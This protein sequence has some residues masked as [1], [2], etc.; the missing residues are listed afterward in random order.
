MSSDVQ[1]VKDV[2]AALA[3]KIK[4]CRE[5]FNAQVVSNALYGLQN[6]KSDVRE[7]KDVLAALA[8]KIEG[9]RKELSAQAVGNAL[10]GL[11]SMS[12]D[13]Q[14]VKDVLAALAP[15]IEGS[16][17]ELDAQ[18]V[19]N[20]LYG[21]Q[22]MS[23][24][25]R[26]VLAVLGA[27]TPKIEGFSQRLLPQHI[28]NALY[29]LQGMDDSV[30][31][32]RI[33]LRVLERQLELFDG[34][35]P[36]RE[37]AQLLQGLLGKR[38]PPASRIRELLG[39]K[40]SVEPESASED[41]ILHLASVMFIDGMALPATVSAAYCD[42]LAKECAK[43]SD[44]QGQRSRYKSK[45]EADVMERLG[46]LYPL[47]SFQTNTRIVDGLEMDLYFPALNLNVELDGPFHRTRT[48]RSFNSK[49]DEY[50]QKKS[51]Q[52]H[53]VDV[54]RHTVSSAVDEIVSVLSFGVEAK[55]DGV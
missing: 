47:Q 50:L 28:A 8:H 40:V 52:V 30:E 22:S 51:I 7:V 1:E 41:M 9:C 2:L 20:A 55:T 5:E 17:E 48:T 54:L 23:S 53:R 3:P 12:S 25:V 29:G 44:L 34:L 36:L 13:V 42:A 39:T 38:S 16:R 14:E 32:V 19:G 43:A 6:M 27:L 11:Q 37:T 18:E 46:A 35:L 15:K 31:S 4:G 49:R 26:E 10:Y 21:L 33:V 45:F 24:D